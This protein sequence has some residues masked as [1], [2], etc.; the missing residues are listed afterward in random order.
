MKAKPEA[1]SMQSFANR[2]LGCGVLSPDFRHCGTTRF[3]TQ[4]VHAGL[5]ADRGGKI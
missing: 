5:I 3:A 1:K 2:N 4:I